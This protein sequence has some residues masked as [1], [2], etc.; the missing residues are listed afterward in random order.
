MLTRGHNTALRTQPGLKL[1][2]LDDAGMIRNQNW[3]HLS[4]E[5]Q[6]N[7]GTDG[8]SDPGPVALTS[9]LSSYWPYLLA[10][11]SNSVLHWWRYGDGWVDSNLTIRAPARSPFVAVPALASFVDG[12]GFIYR[13]SGGD[14]FNYFADRKGAN[15][16]TS[17]ANG[18][19]LSVFFRVSF[20]IMS[21]A[22]R[23]HKGDLSRFS[24]PDASALGAFVTA[25]T[26]TAGDD[27]INT[28]I[29]YQDDAGALQM[30]WQ[31]SASDWQGP[32]TF[33][34]F[35]GADKGTDI[36][37]ITAA[38]WNASDVHI[39]SAYDVSRCYF[40]VKGQVRETHWTGN[41]WNDLG[42]L[43]IK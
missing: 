24:I 32:K 13:R 28:H 41:D 35:Q 21:P 17:W 10:Q 11:D 33:D 16:G 43:P 22:D 19:L 23:N 8:K 30:V 40:Q 26:D 3:D 38:A 12:G 34:A 15:D 2:Y 37:C 27:N 7:N 6:G 42:L 18:R 4:P 39:T 1:Y 36:A 20:P 31:N 14:L 25:R 5:A 9:R 29:V